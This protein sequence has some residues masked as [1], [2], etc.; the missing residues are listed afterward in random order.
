MTPEHAR[1][2]ATTR[3]GGPAAEEER[4]RTG[5]TRVLVLC[6]AAVLVW[7]L[8]FAPTLQHNAQVSPVGT[9]RTVALDIL[10]PIAAT[11]RALQLSR[12]VSETDAATGRT[13]NRP[14]NGVTLTLGGSHHPSRPHRGTPAHQG[15][16]PGVTTTTALDQTH[17]TAANHL[18]V[19]I[20]GDSIGLDLGGPLQND[21]ANT[22]VITATL[23]GHEST[24][25]TRPDYYNWPAELQ[26][27]IATYH[28]Q[29]VVI[30]IGANDPQDFPGPPD[31]PYTSPS[32]NPMYAARVAQF[33]QI[34]Q[35][36][37]AQVIWVGMPPM[38]NGGLSAKL[39]D[40]NTIVQQQAAAQK[41]PVNFIS[42]WTML[43]TAQGLYT[44]YITTASG[45]VVNVR[46]PDGTHLT[47][48]GG[49]VVSQSVLG[50]LRTNLH[51]VLP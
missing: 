43:G 19:L 31:V 17:P 16:L 36:G 34:A 22:G 10:G 7:L 24:G 27:D 46:A 15:A 3:E 21:M 50:Y 1:R 9:R 2:T 45:Q 29:V 14:G 38:Q 35:S 23:D 26:T 42:T 28:P 30:M 44:A 32:W 13:G 51:Y 11:S 49:E 18:R 39:L 8:L 5:W 40:L 12:I 37:G 6:V 4:R 48:A 25:L 20:A 33:M 41:P 47:P